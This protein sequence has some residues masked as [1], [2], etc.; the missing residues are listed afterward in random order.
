MWRPLE[1]GLYDW[2]PLYEERRRL[3]RLARIRV[4]V[5]MPEIAPSF[6]LETKKHEQN[7]GAETA[8]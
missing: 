8:A 6:Y 1:I 2:W 3:D 5:V 7:E 4:R